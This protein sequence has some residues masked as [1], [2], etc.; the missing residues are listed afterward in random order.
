[1]II[2]SKADFRNRLNSTL[3][4]SVLPSPSLMVSV[5]VPV[6]N[7]AAHLYTTLDAL[8]RQ[9][10]DKS[11][12][13]NHDIYEILLLANNCTD[14]SFAIAKKYKELYPKLHLYIAEI[15]LPKE[16]AHIGTAR[17]ILMDEAYQ[18]LMFLQKTKGIIASTDGDTEVDK[19]W[20]YHIINEVQKGNDAVGGRITINN[21]SSLPYYHTLDEMYRTLVAQAESILDPQE[22]DPWP[23]HFQYYGASLAV[24]CDM[25]H[26]AGR[27]PQLPFLEDEAFHQALC[28]QDARIRKSPAVKVKT[29]GRHDG[30]VNIGLSQQLKEWAQMEKRL[31][32]QLVASAK[33]VIETFM[34][35]RIMRTCYN[36]ALIKEDY[37]NDLESAS[38][39]LGISF[40]WLQREVK[41]CTHFGQLWGSIEQKKITSGLHKKWE[42]VLITT[43]IQDLKHFTAYF[44]EV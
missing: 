41:K 10:D 27:L 37:K 25:Y 15:Y 28:R 26:A 44:S 13:I 18:R 30:R 21:K 1:M 4:S 9:T 20:I 19:T 22:H 11:K 33:E 17:R 34:H 42:L 24:T 12:P 8:R 7:E 6:R 39:G 5:I 16:A 23:R 38:C 35:R 14:E 36:K 2:S 43:A 31:E 40:I 29:S 32:P 3:F